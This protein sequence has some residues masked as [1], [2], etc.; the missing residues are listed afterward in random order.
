MSSGILFLEDDHAQMIIYKRLAA[1]HFPDISVAFTDKVCEAEEIL[2]SNPIKLAVL[3][4]M[5]PV[6]NGADLIVKIKADSLYKNVKII[7]VSA[8]ERGSLLFDSLEGL[9]DEFITKPINS[10]KFVDLLTRYI[11]SENIT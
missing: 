4:L 10:E 3:D 1:R 7:V 8:A 5:I 9:V 2:K 6:S 11:D